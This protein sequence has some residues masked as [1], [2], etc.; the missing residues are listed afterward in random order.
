MSI[1]FIYIPSLIIEVE[2]LV[3]HLVTDTLVLVY[4][5]YV[6]YFN[7]IDSH[8]LKEYRILYILRALKYDLLV[9]LS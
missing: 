9:L 2:V 5:D 6:V 7:R 8:H 4:I 3:Q 1:Y